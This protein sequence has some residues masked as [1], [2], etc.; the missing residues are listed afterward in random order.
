MLEPLSIWT[1]S[2]CR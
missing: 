2:L 1:E